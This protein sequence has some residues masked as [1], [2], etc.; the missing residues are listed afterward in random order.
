M[1]QDVRFAL[2]ARGLV[3]SDA[4]VALSAFRRALRAHY[5]HLG[6][7]GVVVEAAC[8]LFGRPSDAVLRVAGIRHPIQIR[9]GTTDILTLDLILRRLEYDFEIPFEPSTIVDAGANIGIASIYF[10]HRFPQARVLAIEPDASNFEMLVRN[11]RPY[12]AIVPVHSALWSHDGEVGIMEPDASSGRA[13]KWGL[14]TLDGPGGV[15]VRS[16][17]MRTLM[18]EHAI[19]RI[20]VLKMDIEGAEREV[21]ESCDWMDDVRC[22]MIE[23]HDRFTPGCREALQRVTGGFSV[24]ERGETSFCLRVPA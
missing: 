24:V 18:R 16:A 22:V 15:R 4:G 3:V 5:R 12:P 20:D 11:T 2:A 17:S 13:G 10:V 21:L 6:L 8:R 7:R 19:S 1:L 23:L 9:F 14:F